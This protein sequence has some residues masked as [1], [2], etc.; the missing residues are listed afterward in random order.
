MRGY[1]TIIHTTQMYMHR[2]IDASM[3]DMLVG[4]IDF[5]VHL[6]S[7]ANSIRIPYI[8]FFFFRDTRKKPCNNA[9]SPTSCSFNISLMTS[10]SLDLNAPGDIGEIVRIAEGKSRFRV[11]WP[12]GPRHT[13]PVSAVSLCPFHGTFGFHFHCSF[14]GTFC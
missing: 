11:Q 3:P 12:K 14:K 9:Q 4:W 10:V 6:I 5:L 7:S 2:C 1:L 8:L 13:L